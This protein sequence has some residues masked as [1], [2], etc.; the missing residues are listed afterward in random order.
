MKENH[1]DGGSFERIPF[2]IMH[3]GTKQQIVLDLTEKLKQAK[4]REPRKNAIRNYKHYKRSEYWQN[5]NILAILDKQSDTVHPQWST[6]NYGDV[7]HLSFKYHDQ[8]T[9][10]D[11][12][13]IQLMKNQICGDEIEM[14][15]L[16]PDESRLVDTSNQFHLWGAKEIEI[17]FGWVHR[18]VDDEVQMEGVVQRPL[19]MELTKK[20][21]M[22]NV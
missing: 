7:W 19:N 21:V 5:N 17:P 22:E 13:E 8:R 1:S 3:P 6:E 10:L 9:T 15:M 20:Q 11:W 2:E 18:R 4:F 14:L 16:F 12:R